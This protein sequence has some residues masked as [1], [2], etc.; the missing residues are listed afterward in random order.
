[1]PNFETIHSV[2]EIPARLAELI[3]TLEAACQNAEPDFLN[4]GEELRAVN[5]DTTFMTQQIY[6]AVDLIEDAIER[7]A[8]RRV[9]ELAGKSM[10]EVKGIQDEAELDLKRMPEVAQRMGA[11]KRLCSGTETITTFLRLI[12]F[13]MAVKSAY[14]RNAQKLFQGFAEEAQKVAASISAI[15]G[16][17]GDDA[18]AVQAAQ[19]S[20]HTEI[21]ADFERL[22]DLAN[23][24]DSALQNAV[25]ASE[26]LMTHSHNVLQNAAVHSQIIAQQVSEI[27]V[28]VQF[29]D[30]MKQRIAH[31]G[32]ELRE[33][34]AGL[35]TDLNNEPENGKADRLNHNDSFLDHQSAQLE[36]IITES[37]DL[38][39]NNIQA[40]EK[41]E[42]EAERLAQSLDVY[43]NSYS[44]ERANG[45]RPSAHDSEGSH[46]KTA[47]DDPFGALKTALQSL[48]QILRKGQE[49]AERLKKN[50]A[51][52]ATQT[53]LFAKQTR[54]V[55]R[56]GYDTHIMALNAGVKASKLSNQRQ[57]FTVMAH[58]IT[59]LARQSQVFVTKIEAILKS[60]T[61]LN[62]GLFSKK[63]SPG[64]LPELIAPNQAGA[65]T[66]LDDRIQAVSA[67]F[68]QFKTKSSEAYKIVG[69]LREKVTHVKTGLSFL[70]ALADE[71]TA[72]KHLTE[73]FSQIVKYRSHKGRELTSTEMETLVRE[74]QT[75][76]KQDFCRQPDKQKD[77]AIS[78]ETAGPPPAPIL[79]TEDDWGDNIELF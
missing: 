66:M 42:S 78:S 1:M 79:S 13:N 33:I 17:L 51:Y 19:I 29:H 52:A 23:A 34:V 65:I 60:V 43:E 69:T 48:H 72:Y 47:P 77:P 59:S 27:V 28:G 5:A 62:P 3:N 10:A 53:A 41:I 12:S 57:T 76:S 15:T 14:S 31:I 32:E 36:L 63:R 20:A 16:R 75:R 21:T 68:Q 24:T 2:K 40:F 4:L 46:V 37:D 30:S 11:I 70:P 45:L 18:Q 9:G 67:A 6:T 58:E 55:N 44:H 7:N 74:C 26:Q 50:V 35:N 71:L 61:A 73:L 8:L 49:L 56:I 54:K 38:Y 39:H 22:Q 25:D 64:N